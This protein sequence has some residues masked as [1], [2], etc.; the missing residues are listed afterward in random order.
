[1]RKAFKEFLQII[2]N[3]VNIINVK[4][5]TDTCDIEIKEMINYITHICNKHVNIQNN[6]K[7]NSQKEMEINSLEKVK[8]LLSD[9]NGYDQKI[10]K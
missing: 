6:D 3:K 10:W 7:Q 5:K 9:I 1:M 2:E 8:L 4:C